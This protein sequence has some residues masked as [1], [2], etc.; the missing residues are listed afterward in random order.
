MSPSPRALLRSMLRDLGIVLLAMGAA[1]LARKLLLGAMGT[2]IVWVTFYPAVMIAAMYG[3]WLTGVLSAGASVLIA[4]FAWPT[5]GN[6]PFISDY[7][8]WLGVSAFLFNCVMISA[9]AEMARRARARAVEAKERAET[10]NRAKSVFLAN[11]SHELRTPLNA[12][13]GFSS[14]MQNDGSLSVEQRETLGIV[15]RSGRYLLD[16]I[17]DVLDMARI[18]A[19]RATV[20]NTVFDLQAMM[21]D[22]AETMRQRAEAKGLQLTLEM[23]AELPRAVKTDESR[24]RQVVL[25]LVGNAI[26]FTSQGGVTL[27]LASRP[28]GDS[29]RVTLVVEVKDSG[30]GIVAGDRQRIFEPFVQIG[31]E[32]GHEGTGLG[33]AITRQFV[34]L[35]GG[36][37]RVESAPG[38]GSVFRVEVPVELVGA[39][40]VVRAA[41][42]EAHL[43][44]LAPGQPDCRVLVVEDHEVNRLLMRR[45]LQQSGVQVRVAENGAEGVEAFR[46]WRPALVWMDWRMPVMDGLEATRRIRALEGG[47]DVKIVALS[48]SVLEEERAQVLAAG[49]DDFLSKPIEFSRM[50]DCL[51]KHLGVR[52]VFDEWP[53]PAQRRLSVALDREALT[54]LPSSLRTELADVLVSLDAARI[55]DVIR[56][57]AES[58]PALGAVLQQHADQFQYTIIRHAVQSCP[59]G[60]S[61][62]GRAV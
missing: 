61:G 3:G 56:R 9:V 21:R 20:E 31:N 50:Y 38:G 17:N 53:I 57:V 16:I 45:L 36:V 2:R 11:M 58:D 47:R 42:R 29:G 40:I 62:E 39:A 28:L 32:K 52:F 41:G 54:A 33:L 5:F 6:R 15:A 8:D 60:A 14:L 23:A 19:G 12:I 35:M 22:L 18:E 10:A 26:K 43:A 24:L 25:N 49:A 51:T 34:E 30:D 13:L 4:V 46:S 37:I 27:R 44:R 55:A 1:V 48:A 7:A 59:G